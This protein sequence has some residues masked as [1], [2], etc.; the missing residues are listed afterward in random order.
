MREPI[1]TYGATEM[2]LVLRASG[3][4]SKSTEMFTDKAGRHYPYYYASQYG[5]ALVCPP[6]SDTEGCQLETIA[7]V[8]KRLEHVLTSTPLLSKLC[9]VFPVAEQRNNRNHW[10]TLHYNLSTRM[11]TVIDSR[12]KWVSFFYSN[13]YIQA[14]LN[15]GLQAIGLHPVK[16][17]TEICTG[18]QS[19]DNTCCGP[20]TAAYI[21]GLAHGASIKEMSNFFMAKNSNDIVQHH[22]YQVNKNL[23][24]MPHSEVCNLCQY[25]SGARMA[26]AQERESRVASDTAIT[27]FTR[28]LFAGSFSQDVN[29]EIG[30]V[31]TEIVDGFVLI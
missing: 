25:S 1:E 4:L 30:D 14:F 29:H 22:Y 3:A 13:R 26:A 20:W 15:E 18:V 6:C 8:I 27:P 12:P 5:P 19:Q 11:A 10:V 2:H 21:E 28:S 17:F 31:D 24:V 23:N 16:Q 9:L 7:E